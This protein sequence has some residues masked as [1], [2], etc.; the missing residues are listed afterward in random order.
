L[1]DGPRIV[2]EVASAV[3]LVEGEPGVRAVL[4]AL[5]RLEPVSIRRISRAVELP[6][7]I[8]AS[9]CG[10]LRK[11]SVVSEQR[12][13]QLTPI[14]RKLFSNG[15]LRIDRAATCPACAGRG[16]VSPRTLS[17]TATEVARSARAAP[18]P[19]FELDQ[20]HCTVETKLRR[21]LAM[22]EADAL[23]GRRV[24]ILG[25]DDL[26]SL[27]IRSIV[28]RFGSAATIS[29]LT[30]IDVDA[31]I[32]AFA[33]RELADA[34]FPVACL[35]HDLREP[36]P[37]VLLGAF[38]TVVTDPPYTVAAADLFLSRTA[39]ALDGAG[40]DVFFS[41]GS[42][43]PGAALCVQRAIAEM[44]FVI[45]RL[46]RDFNE[47]VGA[48]AIGGASHLYHLTST[49]ELHPLV[50]GTC[51]APLYTADTHGLASGRAR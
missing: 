28:R 22:Y 13:T 35:Q 20:C 32:V 40:C 45:R 27:A 14:G 26:T 47:Y 41:F 50:T 31:D 24:L 16:I 33:S 21:V 6:V 51:R 44:G 19:R 12:P 36:L 30:V 42:R 15:M 23:V 8:V 3:G 49:D 25:D 48:G 5:A 7:P 39:D 38:D 9:V 11:R 2:G 18:P 37:P 46:V 4:S 34:P 10:E 1:A 43:R 17:E 29:S